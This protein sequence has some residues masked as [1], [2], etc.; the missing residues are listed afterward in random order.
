MLAPS[1]WSD[2]IALMR[3]EDIEGLRSKVAHIHRWAD[4][5]D[6][7]LTPRPLSVVGGSRS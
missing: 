6:A 5:W 2:R 1:R 7:L 4:E 3:P